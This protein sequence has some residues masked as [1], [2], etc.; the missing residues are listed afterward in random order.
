M[1]TMSLST[2]IN[3]AILIM[4]ALVVVVTFVTLR[5]T[6][7]PVL[8]S[9]K[10][11]VTLVLLLGMAMCARGGLGYVAG[12]GQWAHPLAI[13]GYILGAA[14]LIVAASV[15]FGFKLPLITGPHPALLVIVVLIGAK[16]LTSLTHYLVSRS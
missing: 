6:N 10:L 7:L 1:K 13:V 4:A 12:A 5:G 15:F 9:P 16:V 8:A 3:P 11:S 2:V 14:I